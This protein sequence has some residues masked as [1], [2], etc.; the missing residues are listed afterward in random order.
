MHEGRWMPADRSRLRQLPSN[1]SAALETAKA[2]KPVLTPRQRQV[3][4][5][6]ALGWPAR[7]TAAELGISEQTVKN[8]LD[9]I[10]RSTNAHCLVDALRAMGW[11]RVP[12]R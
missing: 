3:L 1:H 2:P 10:Y 6:A 9:L 12:K 7:V 4:R 5:W 8:H 11:L